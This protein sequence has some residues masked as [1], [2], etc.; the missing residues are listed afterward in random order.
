MGRAEHLKSKFKDLHDR[1]LQI[2]NHDNF[3]LK[4]A[5]QTRKILEAEKGKVDQRGQ[6]AREDDDQIQQLKKELA[7]AEHE[8]SVAQEKESMLQVEALELDRKRQNLTHEVQDAIAAEEA[9]AKPQIDALSKDIGT[10]GANTDAVV[11]EFEDLKEARE[12]LLKKESDLKGDLTQTD[13]KL[14]EAKT[15]FTRV[16][17]EPERA[18]KQADIVQKA[19]LTAEQELKVLD[20][21]LGMQKN[22]IDKLTTNKGELNTK[23][24]EFRTIVRKNIEITKDKENTLFSLQENQKLEEEGRQHCVQRLGP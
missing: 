14:T 18:K 22:L 9:R 13:F 5:S 10:I 20:E 24:L 12:V 4:R 1:V 17:R 21:R 19:F 16:E 11:R 3:L 8:L 2:Y 23:V 7:A 6:I 15:E